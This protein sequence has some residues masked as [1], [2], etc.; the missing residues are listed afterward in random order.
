MKTDLHPDLVLLERYTKE[1][2]TFPRLQPNIDLWT[3]ADLLFRR[4]SVEEEKS[5]SNAANSKN[6]TE[7]KER[8]S[9][10]ANNTDHRSALSPHQGTCN[11]EGFSQESVLSSHIELVLA[12]QDM[13]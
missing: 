5:K 11:K 7:N 12:K 13:K 2:S 9:S 3:K 1:E 6:D 8:A 4:Q 10:V